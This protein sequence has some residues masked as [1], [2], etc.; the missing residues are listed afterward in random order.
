[1]RS[2]TIYPPPSH[3]DAASGIG[4]ASP[5]LRAIVDRAGLDLQGT[6]LLDLTQLEPGDIL[7]FASARPG[8]AQIRDYQRLCGHHQ[9]EASYTHAAI[10]LRD[11]RI[12]HARPAL[13][14]GALSGVRVDSLLA[15]WDHQDLSVLRSHKLSAFSRMEVALAAAAQHGLPYDYAAVGRAV[16]HI[17]S[18]SAGISSSW[19]DFLRLEQRPD[20]VHEALPTGHTCAQL[21]YEAYGEVDPTVLPPYSHAPLML[22]AMLARASTLFDPQPALVAFP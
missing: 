2:T 17:L 22:P 16:N 15:Y 4:A 5:K 6:A 3:A 20:R 1:M 7:L 21:V 12:V 11:D 10:F 19:I 14:S 18:L 9:P 13:T 8:S